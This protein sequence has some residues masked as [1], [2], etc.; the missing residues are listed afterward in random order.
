MSTWRRRLHFTVGDRN[1]QHSYCGMLPRAAAS[2][3]WGWDCVMKCLF[4]FV[5]TC[6]LSIHAVCK[7]NHPLRYNKSQLDVNCLDKFTVPSLEADQRIL[8][9]SLMVFGHVLMH[10]WIVLPDVTLCAAVGNRP[11]AKWRGVRVWTLE[12]EGETE[13]ETD[14]LKRVVTERQ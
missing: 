2:S 3:P 1:T 5:F 14:C 13:R 9:S 12:L 7:Q 4:L 6:F 8:D 10:I 11:K